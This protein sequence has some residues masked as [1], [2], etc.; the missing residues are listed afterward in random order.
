M[1]KPTFY[2]I[3][4]CFWIVVVSLAYFL[5]L[6]TNT[7]SWIA[8]VVC[9]AFAFVG[10]R[11]IPNFIGAVFASTKQKDTLGIAMLLMGLILTIYHANQVSDKYGHW[12]AWWF[13]NLRANFLTRKEH[14]ILAFSGLQYGTMFTIP[15]PHSDYPPFLPLLIGF[16][17]RTIGMQPAVIPY[18]WG[19][20][21]YLLIP[22]IIFIELRSRNIVIAAA[23]LILFATQEPLIKLGT[24]QTADIWIAL[25]LLLAFISYHYCE[26]GQ[27]GKL[28]V[29]SGAMF[30]A[31]LWTK[32][33][34]LLLLLVFLAF[35]A[36]SMWRKKILS[37]FFLGLSL[38]LVALILFKT[39]LAPLNDFFTDQQNI[40]WPYLVD[41]NRYVEIWVNTKEAVQLY[42]S[43]VPYLLMGYIILCL[44]DKHQVNRSMLALVSCFLLYLSIYIFSP[45]NIGWHVQ[46]SIDRLILQLLPA[47]IW[48]IALRASRIQ[49]KLM[50]LDKEL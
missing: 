42:F 16:C 41:W 11:H 27:N 22:T 37:K 8:L 12:D 17:W 30:G 24:S 19:M 21:A 23:V 50:P 31:A 47:M 26:Q 46:T 10:L 49:F 20:L 35:Y 28:I 43:Y 5:T 33:E 7:P 14:W 45:H 32:N 1:T 48:I 38:P 13:W 39:V 29:L 25:F 9:L 40:P 18:A 44:I 36:S 6:V 34:G 15:V 2:T 3:L 4:F